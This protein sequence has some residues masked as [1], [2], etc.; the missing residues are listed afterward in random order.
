MYVRQIH[1]LIVYNCVVCERYLQCT[2][3]N[4]DHCFAVT[5]EED[6][7]EEFY[8]VGMGSNYTKE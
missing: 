5:S 2:H 7:A 1:E 4:L 8:N 6:E 3:E